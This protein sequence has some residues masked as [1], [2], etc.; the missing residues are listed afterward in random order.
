MGDWNK[1][2]GISKKAWEGLKPNQ[3]NRMLNIFNKSPRGKELKKAESKSKSRARKDL[4]VTKTKRKLKDNVSTA[5]N[6]E[7]IKIRNKR[8]IEEA[9]E[10]QYRK[11]NPTSKVTTKGSEAPTKFFKHIRDK[12]FK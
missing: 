5:V 6:A 9:L 8:L 10:S 12:I 3:R 11:N 1:D 7:K 4:K 2:L